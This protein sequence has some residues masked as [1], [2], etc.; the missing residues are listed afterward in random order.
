M[1]LNFQLSAEARLA[2]SVERKALNLVVVGLEPH[3]GCCCWANS[4]LS[5]VNLLPLSM[6]PLTGVG[7]A[8]VELPRGFLIRIRPGQTRLQRKISESGVAQWLACWAHNRKVPGSK[9]GSAMHVLSQAWPVLWLRSLLKLAPFLKRFLKGG[10][11][12]PQAKRSAKSSGVRGLGRLWVMTSHC[13][14]YKW[15]ARPRA[16]AATETGSREKP[17]TA[18]E[19]GAE[20]GNRKKRR[21]AGKRNTRTEE[22]Q[23]EGKRNVK[24]DRGGKNNKTKEKE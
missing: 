1:C 10:T 14:S 7:T 3:G 6:H 23:T 20:R 13:A 16:R 9:P 18:T 24:T 22:Q 2:Q 17:Q 11:A 19:E 8:E 15:N 12:P 21:T 4:G 5:P